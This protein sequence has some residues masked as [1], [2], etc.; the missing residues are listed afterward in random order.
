MDSY[1]KNRFI[2]WAI[3]LIGFTSIVAQVVLMRELVVIFYGNELSL[4]VMLGVWLFWTAIGSS[5]IARAFRKNR[6][7]RLVISLIQLILSLSLPPVL[8]LVRSSKTILGIT[9]GE[10]VGFVPMLLITFVVLAPICLLSGLLYTTAIQL[11]HKETNIA[12]TSIGTVYL[13]EAVG[14]GTG[15]VVASFL[16]LQFLSPAR[17]FFFL[18]FLNLTSAMV[19]GKLSPFRTRFCQTVWVLFVIFFFGTIGFSFSGKFQRLCDKILWRGYN[20]VLTQNT[21]FGNL[22]VTRIGAQISF[23]QNGLLMF[24]APDRLTAEESVHFTLLEHPH[25]EKVL[26]IGGG[27]GGG[28]EE[29]LRHPSV[30]KVV[31]VELDPA[32]VSLAKKFLPTEYVE[33]FKNPKVVI[34]HIDGRRFIKKTSEKFDVIILNLPNPYTAQINRFYTLE[35]FREVNRKLRSGGVF[36][37]KVIS[38]ENAI[39]PELSNFLST[40]YATLKSVFSEIVLIP[41]ETT[42]FIGS[43]QT[44]ELTADPK[45]LVQ[46]LKER[47]LKTLYVRE[48]YLPYQMTKERENYLKSKLH[49]VTSLNR[50]FKPVGYFYDTI[51]WATYFSSGFKKLFLGFTRVKF[52]FIVG[53]LILITLFIIIFR[54]RRGKN[55]LF[56]P[57]ILFSVFGVGFTEISVEVILILGFQVIYGYVYQQLAIIVAGYMIGLAL[58]SRIAISKKVKPRQIFSLFRLCQLL[59]F[60]YPLFIMGFL[61]IFHR[62]SF[63]VLHPFWTGW[64]FPFFT[65]GAGFIG[66]CQFPLANRLYLRTG[67]PI[68]RVAGFLYG[69]D[70]IGS[71]GGAL[72]ASAFFIPI[73]GIFS[74]L[75]I[76]AVLNLCGMLILLFAKEHP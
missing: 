56:T 62:L 41:G 13:L 51:L 10:M 24:T 53:F 49:T 9:T 39:G 34:H 46:R 7:P 27:L 2:P 63:S 38:S 40:L 8:I 18:S 67:R 25:P 36:S 31:Y 12:S 65:G 21:V 37:L 6:H 76:L 55:L 58:G 75:I 61:W 33:S 28:I 32:V 22:A 11:L 59:M 23:F 64:F 52:S 30:K 5:V 57:A 17:I 29:T 15:G 26:L 50:D 45:I 71:S 69:L 48:Y 66:G 3:A 68:E 14:A 70:L 1:I 54:Y 74:T 35:F 16:F 73:L 19:I 42:R 47:K 4:G 43:N 20:L 60:L 72:M 44:G